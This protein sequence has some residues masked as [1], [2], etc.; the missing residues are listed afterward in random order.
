MSEQKYK[1]EEMIKKT[2]INAQA[3]ISLTL[4]L[5]NA[6]ICM[7]Y[8]SWSA[9][10]THSPYKPLSHSALCSTASMSHQHHVFNLGGPNM[11]GFIPGA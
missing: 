6:N 5:T 3:L 9:V 11:N 7:L 10:I 1:K 2:I 4:I 8:V